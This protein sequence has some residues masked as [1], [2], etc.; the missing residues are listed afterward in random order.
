MTD[1]T[2]L[3]CRWTGGALVPARRIDAE[4]ARAEMAEGEVVIVTVDHAR[5]EAS[6][7]H[8]FAVVR[9]AW[10]HL[11]EAL[12]A[13]PWARSAE[14]M[15]KAALIATGWCHSSVTDCGTHAAAERVAASMGPLATQA[16]GYAVAQVSGP[17]VTL[18]TPMSQSVRAMGGADF[19]A[20]KRAVCEWISAKYGWDITTGE[21]AA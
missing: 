12:E 4:M 9:E 14:T 1:P 2:Y 19:A 15:R 10:K 16:H 8:Q 11:P 18:W 5:S 13:M 20:S 3:R 21:I 17:L 6:H 7:R